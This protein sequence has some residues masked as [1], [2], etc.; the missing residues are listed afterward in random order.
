MEAGS[1]VHFAWLEGSELMVLFRSN[2]CPPCSPFR[3]NGSALKG[4]VLAKHL[5][6]VLKQSHPVLGINGS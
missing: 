1:S 6:K 5:Q 2:T 3:V 4:P